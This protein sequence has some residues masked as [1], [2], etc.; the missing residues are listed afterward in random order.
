[1]KQCK[2]NFVDYGI[3][4]SKVEHLIIQ[5]LSRKYEVV[6]VPNPDYLFYGSWGYKH[7]DAK[8]SACIKI[9][10]TSENRFPDFDFC[11][12]ALSYPHLQLGDRYFRMPYYMLDTNFGDTIKDDRAPCRE[13][14]KMSNLCA[15]GKDKALNRK[16]CCFLSSSGWADP[17]R[18][19]FFSKM[20]EYKRIDSGG[21][22]LNNMGGGRIPN[23][24]AFLKDYKFTMAFENSSLAGY[25]TEKIMNALAADTLP[26]YWG[27]PDVGLDFNKEAFIC[28]NDFETIDDVVNE[29]IRIDN[30]D[31][32]YLRKLY[33]PRCTGANYTAWEEN[34]FRFL[35]NIVEQPLAQAKRTS[36]YGNLYSH[37]RDMTAMLYLYS[38]NKF[39][40]K[41]IRKGLRLIE[42]IQKRLK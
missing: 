6:I 12:Y 5:L 18:Y 35:V 9:F 26:I 38:Q 3:G 17:V 20:S 8:Y 25:T 10:Y 36:E 34:L 1:M 14:E 19:E 40:A 33:A 39:L 41:M 2:I 31:E 15:L 23:K 16:F 27:D 30:D 11:D 29:I 22:S 32:E 13:F 37:K 42:K 24:M 28:V 4:L 7:L 21:T